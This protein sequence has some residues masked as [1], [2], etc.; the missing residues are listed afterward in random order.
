M[1][2]TS[3]EASLTTQEPERKEVCGG[4]CVCV[5]VCVCVPFLP[6]TLFPISKG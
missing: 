5:C 6:F 2:F 3:P 4:V 1:S